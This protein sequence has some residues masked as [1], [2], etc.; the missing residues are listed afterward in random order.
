MRGDDLVLGEAVIETIELPHTE[1][2]A[3]RRE[4]DDEYREAD[5]ATAQ[6]EAEHTID[7]S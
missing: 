2:D 4:E 7:G 5:P 1:T 6:Q 3:D